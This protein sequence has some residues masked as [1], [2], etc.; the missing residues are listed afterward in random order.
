[1]EDK[2]RQKPKYNKKEMKLWSRFVVHCQHE[3]DTQ[4]QTAKMDQKH[5]QDL[6]KEMGS[7]STVSPL[8][9]IRLSNSTSCTPSSGAPL[10]FR[11]KALESQS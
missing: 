4:V 1:M 9:E 3:E 10:T 5:Y 6:L 2:S 7:F 11:S 8:T